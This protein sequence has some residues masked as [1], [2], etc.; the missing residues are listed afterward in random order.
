MSRLLPI[1]GVQASPVAY[2]VGATWRKYEDEVRGLH[3]LLPTARLILHPELY[4]SAIGPFGARAPLGYSSRAVAETV[5]GPLTDRVCAL[6]KE[7]GLWLVPGSLY[8]RGEDDCVYNTAIAVSPSGEVV[9]RYRK[10]FPWRPFDGEAAGTEFVVFDIDDVGRAGLMICY[11]GWFPEVAR[12][13]AWMGADVLL[14]PTATGTS[15]RPQEV[16]LAR[17]NAIANQVWVVNVNMGGRVGQGRSVIVD[18]EG[19]VLQEGGAEEEHLTD[20]LDLAAVDRV[21]E[22]G[23]V[24]LNRLWEQMVR[25]GSGLEL[26]MYGGRFVPR[27]DDGSRG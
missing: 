17:A 8:E 23:S 6:A 16:V 21:R 10:L 5:P 22:Y 4:L 20:V 15:D 26:P 18:P 2:D 3:R 24:G 12:H 27:H 11:D 13:L 9:A 25:E 19:H 1:V 7:L 14:H